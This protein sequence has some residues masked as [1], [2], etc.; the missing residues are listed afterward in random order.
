MF[1][2]GT[3]IFATSDYFSCFQFAQSCLSLKNEATGSLIRN[4]VGSIVGSSG[5]IRFYQ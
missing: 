1:A 4:V 2:F 5:E 3:A